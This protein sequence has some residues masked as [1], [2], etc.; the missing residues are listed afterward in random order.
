[1]VLNCRKVP[2]THQGL[3]SQI[4][5]CSEGEPFSNLPKNISG[6]PGEQGQE[7]SGKEEVGVPLVAQW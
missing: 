7:T 2:P 1:M 4:C 6:S 3:Y 5:A